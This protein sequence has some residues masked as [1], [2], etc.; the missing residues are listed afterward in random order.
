MLDVNTMYEMNDAERTFIETQTQ[1]YNI[2]LS[3]KYTRRKTPHFTV[4]NLRKL[5]STTLN[6][7]S[8][9]FITQMMNNMWM[10]MDKRQKCAILN[11]VLEIYPKENG[12]DNSFRNF[13]TKY[14]IW[15]ILG[16]SDE[17][18]MKPNPNMYKAKSKLILLKFNESISTEIATL[19]N[20][21]VSV[22]GSHDMPIHKEYGV[23]TKANILK[24]PERFWP[25][26]A[27]LNETYGCSTLIN[28]TDVKEVRRFQMILQ[29]TMK[30]R[31]VTIGKS[32]LASIFETYV[33]EP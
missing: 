22:L 14:V 28:S 3:T 13:V 10:Y 21:H 32:E 11:A 18:R 24:Y 15:K 12:Y 33:K 6:R 17:A 8:R 27:K 9:D 26:M 30:V 5:F 16:A 31:F 20:D 19:I 1:K 25:Y 29:Y 23:M 2:D 7:L 4:L